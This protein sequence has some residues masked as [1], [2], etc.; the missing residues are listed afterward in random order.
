MEERN[1][2]NLQLASPL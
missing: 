2:K 1:H